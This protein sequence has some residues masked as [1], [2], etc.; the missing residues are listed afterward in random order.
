MIDYYI[1]RQPI[2]DREYKTVAYGVQFH[3]AE[4][5]TEEMSGYEVTAKVL[6]GG[7]MEIG[8]H[9]LS[10]NIP[11]YIKATK[12]V[13]ADEIPSL[14]S[15]QSLGV[16]VSANGGV[17]GE[18]LTVCRQLKHQGYSI[19]LDNFNGAEGAEALLGVADIVAI[20]MQDEE[21]LK[22]VASSARKYPVRLMAKKVE[23]IEEHNRA[24]NLNFQ[25]FQGHFFCQ[26]QTVKGKALPDSKLAILRA[27]QQVMAAEAIEDVRE[28]VT[29]D[30]ALSYRLLKY[31]NS[32]AFGRHHKIE[33][34][35]QALSL[36]GLKNIQQW[37]SVILLASLGN[38]KPDELVRTAIT[39]GRILEGIAEMQARP[40][41]SDYFV[42]GLFSLLDALLDRPMEEALDRVFLP[43]DVREGLTNPDSTLGRMLTLVKAI[44]QNDWLTV[45]AN[46]QSAGLCSGDL[47]SVYVKALHWADEQAA[48]FEA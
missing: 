9:K 8:L 39:R 21:K 29:Y 4:G 41:P 34:I 3:Q 12:E 25:Y 1:G 32:A 38:D 37:L 2:L 11:V 18:L 47:M 26:S 16:E 46:C 10:G 31:I 48:G 36:L 15:P 43:E 6:V 33:S 5:L 23:S 45:D 44:E 19:L 42:L 28:V 27:M 22:E 35:Q 40:K 30:V 17:D 7:L 24:V 13:M 20:D 14:F